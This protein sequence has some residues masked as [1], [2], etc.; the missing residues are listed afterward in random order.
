MKKNTSRTNTAEKGG[1]H[2]CTL[3]SRLL[4]EKFVTAYCQ[5]LKKKKV[6]KQCTVHTVEYEVNSIPYSI[7]TDTKHKT[8]QNKKI[9]LGFT[10][11]VEVHTV[12]RSSW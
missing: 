11:A 2:W 8:G 10:S 5:T 6:S 9:V 3:Y 4:F 7:L 12:Q 1:G